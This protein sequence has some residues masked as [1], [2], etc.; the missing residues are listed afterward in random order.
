VVH[1]GETITPYGRSAQNVGGGGLV[2][3][4]YGSVI[5]ERD[6]GRVVAD[7][8]RQNRLLGVT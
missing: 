1:G 6:L 8:V 7:A 3:N 5:S 2:V 4:V